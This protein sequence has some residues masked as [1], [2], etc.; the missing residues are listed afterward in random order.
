MPLTRVAE[1]RTVFRRNG[2]SF[3]MK[4]AKNEVPCFITNRD[5]LSLA[6]NLGIDDA[7]AIFSAYRSAIERAASDSYDRSSRH[8]YEMLIVTASDL[9]GGRQ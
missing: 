5:L 7:V 9:M 4:D 3:L 6:P 2:V 1:A 8:N